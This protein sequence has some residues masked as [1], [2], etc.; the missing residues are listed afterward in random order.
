MCEVRWK[1]SSLIL[2]RLGG[3]SRDGP[4]L[5]DGLLLVWQ[6]SFLVSHGLEPGVHSCLT[7]WTRLKHGRTVAT[8]VGR[9]IDWPGR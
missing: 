4:V 1:D 8:G 2:R 6:G 5:G 9:V 7:T 3:W